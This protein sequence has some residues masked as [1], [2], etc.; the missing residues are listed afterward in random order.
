MRCNVTHVVQ[1]LKKKTGTRLELFIWTAEPTTGVA[2]ENLAEKDPGLNY[3]YLEQKATSFCVTP[4]WCTLKFGGCGLTEN[5]IY[6]YSDSWM[7][8]ACIYSVL[9]IW[10]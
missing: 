6:Y 10:R 3:N 9:F 4:V 1:A 7:Q 5:K 2:A 8:L